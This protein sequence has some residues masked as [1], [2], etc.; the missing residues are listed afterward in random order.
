[1]NKLQL[2]PLLF[3]ISAS[4]TLFAAGPPVGTIFPE[5]SP[6]D[7]TGANQNFQELADRIDDLDIALTLDI[8]SAFTQ[9]DQDILDLSSLLDSYSSSLTTEF[10]QLQDDLLSESARIDAEVSRLSGQLSENETLDNTHFQTL[11]D[12]IAGAAPTVDYTP[13]ENLTT[14]TFINVA[15]LTPGVCDIRNDSFSFDTIEKTYAQDIIIDSSAY[16]ITC[17]DATYYWDY[18][19]GMSSSFFITRSNTEN[20]SVVLSRPWQVVKGTTRIGESWGTYANRTFSSEEF[21]SDNIYHRMTLIGVEDVTVPAGTFTDCLLIED[22]SRV[23]TSTETY[24]YYF[25]EA[26]GMVRRINLDN[27]NDWQLQ[28]FTEN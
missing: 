4:S 27:G 5:S 12:R 24:L 13:N 1:M 9:V 11:N 10:Y 17:A 20:T 23:G 26:P 8:E 16:D 18:A 7:P 25:C 3:S 15:P 6:V 28:S 14:R 19:D 2:I 22:E 21:E